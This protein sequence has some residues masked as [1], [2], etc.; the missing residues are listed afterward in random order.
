M[1]FSFV[2][3]GAFLAGAASAFQPIRPGYCPAAVRPARA[4]PLAMVGGNAIGIDIGEGAQRDVWSMDE[5]ATQYGVQKAPGVQLTS[6][7]GTDWSL[8][9][10]EDIAAGTPVVYVP[11]GLFLS[12]FGAAQELGGMMARGENRLADAKLGDQIPLFRIVV[13]I[14]AEYEKGADSPFFPWLNALP[15]LYSNGGSMTFA[16]FALLPPYVAWLAM[17]ERT[18][19]VNFQKALKYV[20]LNKDTISD[21]NLMKWAYNVAVTRSIE[22]NGE[23]VIA[24]MADMFN[25]GTETE[26]EIQFDQEGNCLA[27]ATR[28]VPAGSPLRISLGDP[29]DP[30]PLFA[31]YG[32]LDE[33]SPATFC[34]TMHLQNEMQQLGFQFSDLLFYKDTGDISPQVYDIFL[35]SVLSADPNLQQQFYQAHMNGDEGT[36]Q[37]FHQQ[38][39]EYTKE[40]LQNHVN[41]MLKELDQLQDD[42]RTKDPNRYP[43]LPVIM[44][45]N[46]FVKESFLR[47]KANLDAM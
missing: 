18:N 20:D 47:V 28:D 9:T 3:T 36:K 46:E 43:R 19:C 29:R 22:V 38:Y 8:A 1:R 4:G 45:H 42:V 34:K 14:L 32:F 44:K 12:S 2:L 39:F 11:N 6:E 33:T 41:G 40:A 26:V 23:R 25:H 24:P 35:Y 21:K 31:T 7:D 16:C 5:W 37:Q 30:S 10:S 15:R 17:K 27:Y 13:K